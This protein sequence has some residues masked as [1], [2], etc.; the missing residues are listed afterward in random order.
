MQSLFRHFN[1]LVIWTLYLLERIFKVLFCSL[2]PN[3]TASSYLRCLLYLQL[4]I[5]TETCGLI[6]SGCEG[7]ARSQVIPYPSFGL[8][9]YNQFKFIFTI[10]QGSNVWLCLW[11][12]RTVQTTFTELRSM[13][14][15]LYCAFAWRYI[16]MD[17]G[18]KPQY[19]VWIPLNLWT[20]L[21]WFTGQL[22]VNHIVT[23]K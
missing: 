2:E 4:I 19:I 6:F 10:N 1:L 9:E 20:H 16:T 7:L 22:D 15:L 21:L 3:Y 13:L 17:F 18:S 23:W 14:S 12:N 11:F 8:T 5:L